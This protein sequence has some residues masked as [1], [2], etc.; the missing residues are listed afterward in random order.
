MGMLTAGVRLGLGAATAAA[1]GSGSSEGLAEV[2]S[3]RAEV[4]STCA[5]RLIWAIGMCCMARLLHAAQAACLPGVSLCAA[6]TL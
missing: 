2:E 6:P 3:R 4:P 1:A 5:R